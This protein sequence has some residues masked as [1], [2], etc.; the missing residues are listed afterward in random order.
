MGALRDGSQGAE[1]YPSRGAP[2]GSPA[3]SCRP[4]PPPALLWSALEGGCGRV[5]I[6]CEPG[7]GET[8]RARD[9]PLWRACEYLQRACGG[10]ACLLGCLRCAWG[11]LGLSFSLRPLD[12]RPHEGGWALSF[13]VLCLLSVALE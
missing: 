2:L 6:L 1:G 11:G 9:T 3:H 5:H 13:L 10:L 8:V 7:G 12:G 4:R